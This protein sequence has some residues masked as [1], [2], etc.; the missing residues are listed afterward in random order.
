MLLRTHA[1][2]HARA[3]LGALAR[4]NE[5]WRWEGGALR[6]VEGHLSTDAVAG[7]ALA[8]RG[9]GSGADVADRL[10]RACHIHFELTKCRPSGNPL[11]ASGMAAALLLGRCHGVAKKCG[12]I[13]AALI[14]GC[15]S[16]QLLPLKVRRRRRKLVFLRTPPS[17]E[18]WRS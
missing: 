16:E 10:G 13:L 18:R 8:A 3:T 5:P 9:L 12:E 7:A 15:S 17:G 1:H 11:P 6:W 2:A 14:G 4:G